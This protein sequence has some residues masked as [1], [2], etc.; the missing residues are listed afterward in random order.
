MIVHRLSLFCFI[1]TTTILIGCGE[2]QRL[3]DSSETTKEL[4]NLIGEANHSEANEIYPGWATFNSYNKVDSVKIESSNLLNDTLVAVSGTT[5]WTNAYNK[6]TTHSVTFYVSPGSGGIFNNVVNTKGLRNHTSSD[7]YEYAKKR[8][9]ISDGDTLDVELNNILI[10]AEKDAGIDIL[11]LDIVFSIRVKIEDLSW[12][13]TSSG[14]YVS[15]TF[16]VHNTS[17]F[18]IPDIKYEIEYKDR[19]GVVFK[20]E[21]GTVTYSKL[22]SGQIEEVTFFDSISRRVAD[23]DVSLKFDQDMLKDYVLAQDYDGDECD[24]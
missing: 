21:D 10:K 13:N 14:D 22:N 17:T 8:G 5:Y 1:L 11:A 23:V 16:L 6:T 2:D 9:C 12:K 7:Y 3:I 20:T 24:E 19:N 18:N 4:I 15:G